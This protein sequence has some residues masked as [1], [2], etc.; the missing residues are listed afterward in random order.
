MWL[1]NGRNVLDINQ[2]HFYDIPPPSEPNYTE[3]DI[4]VTQW[5][6]EGWY[7]CMAWN[8]VGEDNATIQVQIGNMVHHAI[9][10]FDLRRFLK[11]Y[12]PTLSPVFFFG[13]M[14]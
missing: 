12:V 11:S 14:S 4:R 5:K 10:R 1:R 8:A 6:H 9:C 7:T 2:H 3:L 13:S